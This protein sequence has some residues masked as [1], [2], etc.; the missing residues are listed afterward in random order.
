MAHPT[1]FHRLK[2][3]GQII[4]DATGEIFQRFNVIFTQTH[5][6]GRGQTFHRRQIIA[7]AHFFALRIELFIFA[8][9]MVAGTILDFLSGFL[10]KA[11]NIGNFL[12]R[13]ISHFFN[14]SKAF[15]SQ[16]LGNH[17][18]DIQCFHEQSRALDKF[19]LTAFAFLCLGHNIN[20][21]TGQLRSEPH[22]LPAATNGQ[23]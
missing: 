8:V 20:V 11:F 12:N 15:R 23:A 22:I 4:G 10:V 5:Q 17:F 14:R 16:K 7:D 13:H 21:P 2:P 18:I 19:G 1:A 9:Q 6:H 3:A